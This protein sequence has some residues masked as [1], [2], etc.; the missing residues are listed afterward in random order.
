MKKIFYI[1][2]AALA[3]AATSCS[4]KPDIDI[5]TNGG[6]GLEFVHFES[7][8]DAWLV[9]ADDESY[10]Y[11]IVVATTKAPAENVTYSVSLGDRTT[12][13]EGTDFSIANKSVTIKS[14]EYASSIPISV[15][16]D[17][18]GEGF[19]IEL[20][21]SV[22][23]S[24]INPSYGATCYIKVKSDKITIDWDWLVGSWECQDYGYYSGSNDG[25][26]Y[27]VA[28]AKTNETTGTLSGI[29]GGGALE[30]T[31]DFEAKTL[32]FVGNQYSQDAPQYEA[33]LFFVAVDPS[34]DYDI[35]YDANENP[36]L[37]YP[38][39]ATLS[40]AGIVIDNY[41]FLLV[42]GPYDG[43]TFAGGEKST[44]TR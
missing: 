6:E 19:E 40:P 20:I 4:T 42:G 11:N 13:V 27:T 14:G 8:S 26:P 28:I 39:V 38:V 37:E 41:D 10:D 2:I 12:G 32:T 44:L 31:V 16:Y 7:A 18:T 21:L 43:Y 35:F 17:T 22:E 23:E 29:W 36:D 15:L 1:C 3:V 30:F 24:L 25:D 9:T 5:D 34:A 33:Q